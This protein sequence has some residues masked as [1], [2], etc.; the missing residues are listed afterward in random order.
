MA[1]RV[2]YRGSQGFSLGPLGFLIV[3]NLIVFI[4]TTFRPQLIFLLG[5][6]AQDLFSQPWTI[7]TNMFV[8]GG[9]G[10][11]F[12]NML[13]L[14]FYGSYLINLVGEKKFFAVYFLGGLLGNVA[15]LLLA[16]SFAI[17]IG[18]S[19]AVFAV[20]GALTVLRPKM[21]VYIFPL[22]VPLPL[23]VVVIGGF[24]IMTSPGI[25]WQAH[26]GGLVLG[27]AAGY[28]FRKGTSR[29]YY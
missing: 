17:A 22:P 8:H 25:A 24:F 3:A 14:Y 9:L 28:L 26:L 18:A 6:S 29:L 20:G 19:G 11:I 5:L 23:W 16:P 1:F 12:A 21:T 2:N 13:T 10:H 4:A 15:F 27:L 7:V